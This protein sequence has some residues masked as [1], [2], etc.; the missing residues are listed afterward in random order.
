MRIERSSGTEAL[1]EDFGLSDR[2]KIR[3]LSI[4]ES[5]CCHAA[6]CRTPFHGL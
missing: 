2:I 5:I 1:S 4:L 6:R 3:G